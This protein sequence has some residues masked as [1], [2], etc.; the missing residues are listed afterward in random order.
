MKRLSF[1]MAALT[2]MF[3]LAGSAQAVVI[4]FEDLY[5]SSYQ[6]IPSGYNGFNWDSAARIVLINGTI[7]PGSGYNSGSVS[8]DMVAFNWSG[9]TPSNIDL[10]G[11][12]TFD[13]NGAYFTS[14]WQDQTISFTG[15]NDGSSLYTSS[16]YSINTTSPLWIE[17]NWTGIDRLQIQ[18]AP[19]QWWVM[20]DFTYQTSQIPSQTPVP[21]PAT[22]TLLGSGLTGFAFIRRKLER[23][24]L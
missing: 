10:A 16:N 20:D 22:L 19:S 17:L 5:T 1:L 12:G 21:E 11:T 6:D 8:G 24:N 4:D 3:A 14:A 18:N 9:E 23:Q 7:I 2:V 15:Y 13:F